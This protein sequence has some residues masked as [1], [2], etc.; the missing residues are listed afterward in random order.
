MKAKPVHTEMADLLDTTL[1]DVL[2]NGQV[3]QDQEGNPV[4]ITPTAA[5]LSVV[6]K[7][8]KDLGVQTVA[9]PNT[10]AGDFIQTAVRNH[11]FPTLP[12]V[13][14]EEDDAATG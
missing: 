12:P 1:R 2:K 9:G 14:T 3:V 8:L 11:K 13:D 6:T 4:T 5:M 10:A 7:R